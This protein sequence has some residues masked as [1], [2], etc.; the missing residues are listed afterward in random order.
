MTPYN[1]LIGTVDDHEAVERAVFRLVDAAVD[2]RE[3]SLVGKRGHSDGWAGRP[4]NDHM[5]HC[6]KDRALWDSLCDLLHEEV[7]LSHPATGPIVVLGH[8]VTML[9]SLTEVSPDQTVGPESLSA[10]EAA[11]FY[12]GIDEEVA[13][14]CAAAVKG[15]HFLLIGYGA[16]NAM[17]RARTVLE[18]LAPR[19]I[20]MQEAV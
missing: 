11:L 1:I 7:S 12:Y 6:T 8:L 9:V 14:E 17:A 10:L 2:I 4:R 5:D 18:T 16:A 13:I 3:F 15:N 20:C 19:S